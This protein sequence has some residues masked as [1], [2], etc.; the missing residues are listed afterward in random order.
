METLGEK[1][2]MRG[3]S[4]GVEQHGDVEKIST[5]P[6]DAPNEPDITLTDGARLPASVLNENCV[7]RVNEAA[8]NK[9]VDCSTSEAVAILTI[10]CDCSFA[11]DIM[12]ELG[13][14][15]EVP[16]QLHTCSER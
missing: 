16:Y 3:S 2:S 10:I 12:A 8:S 4:D 15:T 7:E 6:K 5:V 1:V 13:G 14:I 9:D 11:V